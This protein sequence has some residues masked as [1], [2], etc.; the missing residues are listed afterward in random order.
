M[1]SHPHGQARVSLEEMR[2]RPVGWQPLSANVGLVCQEGDMS[3]SLTGWEE[4][5]ETRPGISRY[6]HRAA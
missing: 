5:D 6:H 4:G 2:G 1:A 3:S